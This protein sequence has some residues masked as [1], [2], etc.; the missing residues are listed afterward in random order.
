MSLLDRMSQEAT[1]M[2]RATTDDGEG[3][4]VSSWEPSATFQ[5]ACARDS[6]Q[7]AALGGKAAQ[8]ASWTLLCPAGTGLR[9]HDVVRLADGTTLRVTSAPKAAPAAS[10]IRAEAVAAEEWEVPA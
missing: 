5:A 7:V 3:G 2:R 8:T 10:G 6:A 9:L 1:L 4:T